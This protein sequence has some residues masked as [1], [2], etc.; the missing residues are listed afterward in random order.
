MWIHYK[1]YTLIDIA[2]LNMPD[3]FLQRSMHY[4]LGMKGKKKH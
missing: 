3:F 1:L 4:T 2:P